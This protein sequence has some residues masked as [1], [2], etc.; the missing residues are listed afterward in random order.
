MAT[1]QFEY[2]QFFNWDSFFPS[3]SRLYQLDN[4]TELEGSVKDVR[5]LENI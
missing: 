2:R 5:N 1:S 3:D 4:K